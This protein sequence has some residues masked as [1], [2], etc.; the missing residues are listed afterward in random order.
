[1]A[2][3]EH[4]IELNEEQ[5][6]NGAL[7]MED[8]YAH[9]KALLAN[10]TSR[11]TALFTFSDFVALGAIRAVQEAKLRIPQDIAIVGYDDIDFA[12]CLEAPLTT[13]GVP[14]WQIGEEVV[15]MLEKRMIGEACRGYLKLPVELVVRQSS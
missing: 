12:F 15:A 5:I 6:R 3:E 14:K 4:N 9:A 13:V 7:T 11:L 2:L 10:N 8:G 1:M